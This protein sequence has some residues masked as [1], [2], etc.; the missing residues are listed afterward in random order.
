MTYPDSGKTYP[1]IL[2][3]DHTEFEREHANTKPEDRPDWPLT[4]FD[5]QDW[6]K[7]FCK[8]ANEHG[9]KDAK[10]EPVDEGWMIG[11]F[12]NALMRGWD[13]QGARS[14]KALDLD[15]RCKRGCTLKKVNS[16]LTADLS[17]SFSA[18]GGYG[19]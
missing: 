14:S 10:S 15:V 11:W 13:E 7:A 3:G 2:N 4:S 1:I 5:A 18:T 19:K 9:F 16:T 8:I 6:A 12:A 17:Q